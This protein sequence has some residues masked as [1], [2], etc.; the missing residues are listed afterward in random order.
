MRKKIIAKKTKDKERA[1]TYISRDLWQ[2]I[3]DAAAE[4]ATS[5]SHIMRLA[6]MDYFK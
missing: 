1:S 3:K 4:Q 2:K 6:L 5:E